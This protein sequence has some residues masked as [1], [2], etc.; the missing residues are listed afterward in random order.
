MDKTPNE[1]DKQFDPGGKGE[2]PPLWN[3]AVM[4]LSS[5]LL[6]E[7]FGHGRLAVC[8][9]CSFVCLCLSVCFVYCP[10]VSGDHF[11]SELKT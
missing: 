3:A 6:G 2:K 11:F 8:A 7:A 9:S 5:F 4:V 10:I 1:E